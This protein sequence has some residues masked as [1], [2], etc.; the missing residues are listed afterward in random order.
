MQFKNTP[1]AYGAVTKAFH[2]IMALTIIAMLVVGFFMGGVED[3]TTKLTLYGLHKS[4]GVTVLTLA[5]LRI[6]WHI[7][8]KKPPYVESLKPWEK[9]AAHFLHLCLYGAMIGMPLSGWLMSSAVSTTA[10]GCS[11]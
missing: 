10:N 5:V 3:L 4:V 11:R 1:F 2:W 9:A 7:W 8:S 6:L